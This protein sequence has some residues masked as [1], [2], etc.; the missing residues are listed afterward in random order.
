[1]EKFLEKIKQP[2]R[3]ID[4]SSIKIGGEKNIPFLPNSA[5]SH[6]ALEILLNI[7]DNYSEVLKTYWGDLIY[8]PIEWAL[9]AEKEADIIA[10][11]ANF[12]PESSKE[13]IEKG[14]EQIKEISKVVTKPLIVTGSGKRELDVVL[15]P[16]ISN[17]L[18]KESTIGI[19]TEENFRQ[20]LSDMKDCKHSIIARSPIDIN[21]AKELNILIS[22]SGI[23]SD[24]IFIDPTSSALGYSLDYT[25]SIIERIKLAAFE[26]DSKLNMPIITFI[27]EECF[28]TKESK[29]S[30][31]PKEWG[32]LQDRAVM[33]EAATASAMISAGANVIV[34]WHK[35]TLKSLKS[36]R[37]RF[38]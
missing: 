5:K 2:I 21:L 13:E 33:W 18:E 14:L 29:S 7:P 26:G 15:I 8:N 4:L 11:K 25:Y 19:L 32:N 3:E 22:D 9:E 36:F 1:M 34:M 27:G 37:E 38:L 6:F 35:E 24:K 16:R 17:I 23:S 28:K 31:F 10:V 12:S 30:A 20:I